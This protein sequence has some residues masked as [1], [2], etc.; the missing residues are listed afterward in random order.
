M[1][2]GADPSLVFLFISRSFKVMN[3]FYSVV[4]CNLMRGDVHHQKKAH[5]ELKSTSVLVFVSAA[6]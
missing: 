3:M 2:Q 6:Y 4:C 1:L 5:E